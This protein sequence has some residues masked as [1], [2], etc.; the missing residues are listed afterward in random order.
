MLGEASQGTPS[1]PLGCSLE[2]VGPESLISRLFGGL[3]GILRKYVR[4][5]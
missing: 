4:S 3:A 1:M 2:H 5:S